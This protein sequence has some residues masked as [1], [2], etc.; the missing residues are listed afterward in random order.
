MFLRVIQPLFRIPIRLPISAVFHAGWAGGHGL[1]RRPI[2]GL[3]N[4]TAAGRPPTR[5]LDGRSPSRP[6]CRLTIPGEECGA[7]EGDRSPV[8]NLGSSPPTHGSDTTRYDFF[9]YSMLSGEHHPRRIT[10]AYPH[11]PSIRVPKLSPSSALTNLGHTQR[12][13]R[14]RPWRLTNRSRAMLF[15]PDN[16]RNLGR[17]NGAASPVREGI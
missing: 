9:R 16:T 3:S 8:V 12:I 17:F 10:L 7:G 15:A 14:C 1:V 2:P 4:A 13:K 11:F 5:I 6:K